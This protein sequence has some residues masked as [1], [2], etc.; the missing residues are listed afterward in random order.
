M[1]HYMMREYDIEQLNLN[2]ERNE[3]NRIGSEMQMEQETEEVLWDK[4][5]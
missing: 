2:D 1:E 5:D 3:V 4:I